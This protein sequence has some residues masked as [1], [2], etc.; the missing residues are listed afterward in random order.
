MNDRGAVAMAVA[1]AVGALVVVPLPLLVW[2]GGLGV[3]GAFA[4]RR[5]LLLIVAVAVLCSGLAARAT[6]HQQV[7]PGPWHGTVEVLHV[8]IPENQ[9]VHAEVRAGNRHLDLVPAA[10]DR[11]TIRHAEPGDR[12]AVIGRVSSL[13][14][15]TQRA[16]GSHVAGRLHAARL[17]PGPPPSWPWRLADGVRNRVR[18]LGT[19]LPVSEQA[20]F[21]G[22]VLGDASG[23]S[24]F[25]HADFQAS[26]LMHLLVAS[27][28]NVAFLLTL[29]GPLLVRIGLR[30]RWLLTGALLATYA[31]VTGLEPSVLRAATMA[32]VAT[33]AAGLGRPVRSWRTLAIAVTA[34]LV[35][36]PFLVHSV[37][38]LLSVGASAGILA[39]A[40]PV[41]GLA[42]GPRWVREPLA[43]TVGAQV[44]VAPLL[45]GFPGGLPV[46]TLPA[47]LLA[48][49]PAG[50]VMVLGLPCLALAATHLGGT[51]LA[52]WVP[53][54][55]LGWI[56][57][58]A[59][60]T[61]GMGLGYLSA[62]MV[63]V[64]LA[65]L[66]GA[67]AAARFGR[68]W[69]RRTATMVACGAVLWPVVVF[70]A[71]P[72]AD[73]AGG[74][75]VV[76]RAATTVVVLTG[77]VP[78]TTLLRELS[79]HKVGRADLVVLPHGD[80]TDRSMLRAVAY[81]ARIGSVLTPRAGSST[82]WPTAVAR[83]GEELVVGRARVEVVA[84]DPVLAVHVAEETTPARH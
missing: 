48:A 1:A 83:E 24:A 70:S 81:R 71:P 2:I 67:L 17:R 45:L 30:A 51:S 38:F 44:G 8:T 74:V 79:V 5:P 10:S 9:Q 53:R 61:A 50:L 49:V 58:V 16:R 7:D 39:L 36:D 46:A 52:V 43:V 59:R 26:G 63:A 14:A 20:L 56:D 64:A 62:T 4:G 69:L 25:Q 75:V 27:G 55:L 3:V 22:F 84:T 78:T 19:A 40:R 31:L 28:E 47:N 41:A 66:T 37:A 32:A 42:P 6:A 21:D 18:R 82:R 77:S 34:L 11:R 72:A 80:A 35:A 57:R 54:L 60:T 76:R 73:S 33:G 68:D 65:G 12:F 15:R 23:Q 29:A 13:D